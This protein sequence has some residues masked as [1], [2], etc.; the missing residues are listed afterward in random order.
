M[1]VIKGLWL[2]ITVVEMWYTIVTGV[3]TVYVVG[4]RKKHPLPSGNQQDTR[5][6]L[7]VTAVGLDQ[8]SPVN[9]WYIMWMGV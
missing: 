9:C 3:I 7:C 2:L 1:P 8:D 4:A 5:R 6:K